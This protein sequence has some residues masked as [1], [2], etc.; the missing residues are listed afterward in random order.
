MS[1]CKVNINEEEVVKTSFMTKAYQILLM[2]L[3]L[4]FIFPIIYMYVIY[5]VIKQIVTGKGN[6]ISDVAS[7]L[8]D[9]LGLLIKDRK[10][11]PEYFS[12]D[13]ITEDDLELI[14]LE[15]DDEQLQN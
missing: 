7:N 14:S 2:F 6:K 13:D 10:N 5:M 15:K 11:K 9:G 8:K 3:I 12:M 1:C 4:M